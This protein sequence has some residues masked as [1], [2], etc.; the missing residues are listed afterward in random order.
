MMMKSRKTMCAATCDARRRECYAT[1]GEI[2]FSN[3]KSSG[4]I[5]LRKK[6]VILKLE[7]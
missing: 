1:V 6:A 7:R 2:V 5:A 4:A 3:Q